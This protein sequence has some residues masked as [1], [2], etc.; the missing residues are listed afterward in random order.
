MFLKI[1]F[2]VSTFLYWFGTVG[3]IKVFPLKSSSTA[4][5]KVLADIFAKSCISIPTSPPYNAVYADI[6]EKLPI[7]IL[8]LKMQKSS[9]LT[10]LPT[11]ITPGLY[12]LAF[13]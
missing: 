7:V 10:W 3:P 2:S 4:Y 12:I 9:I 6:C 1:T 5:T 13:Y 11:D 8:P